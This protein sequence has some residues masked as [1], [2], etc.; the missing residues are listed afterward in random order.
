MESKKGSKRK[1]RKPW[2]ERIKPE[3]RW[4][5]VKVALAPQV[6]E[7]VVAIQ[8]SRGEGKRPYSASSVIRRLITK[9]LTAL[10]KPVE[11][12]DAFGRL[13][14]EQQKW[15]E[16]PSHP[17]YYLV[18]TSEGFSC[19]REVPSASIDPG[20]RQALHEISMGH[21]LVSR[22]GHRITEAREVM[23]RRPEIDGG[24]VQS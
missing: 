12:C 17:C 2:F 13:D 10:G 22:D 20:V 15:R 21:V 16:R 1:P 11:G 7:M 8:N 4:V 3:Q 18:C 19:C 9:G 14:P 24:K 5:Q 23:R 6:A